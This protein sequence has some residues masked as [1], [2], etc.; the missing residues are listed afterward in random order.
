MSEKPKRGS[1]PE[2]DSEQDV[3]DLDA[4][5]RDY[6]GQGVAYPNGAERLA[7]SPPKRK[8]DQSEARINSEIPR[9]SVNVNGKEW[10]F[11][12]NDMKDWKH[13]RKRWDEWKP[14]ERR[15]KA[16][17]QKVRHFLEHPYE[18]DYV[19]EEVPTTSDERM[20][21][22][23]A[24][25]VFPIAAIASIFTVGVAAP[26]VFLA[27]LML[28]VINKGKSRFI[29]EHAKQAL[30][31]QVAATLGWLGL[32]LAG[33]IFGVVL[34]II[35]AITIVGIVAIPFLWLGIVLA[36]LASLVIP[37]GA[38]LYSIFGAVA[39]LNGKTFKYPYVGRWVR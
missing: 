22:A 10:Q 38:V 26:L 34:T 15:R 37:F 3:V 2:F 16:F 20:W 21:A 5:M 36:M 8:N 17:E 14:S 29:A 24:H 11:N 18:A 27:P 33:V 32:G 25:G 19:S 6:D 23:L 30:A 4:L 9:V 1:L 12:L 13:L 35:L 39:A 28:L 7:D 31:A